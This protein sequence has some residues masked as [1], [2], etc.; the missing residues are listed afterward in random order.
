VSEGDEG[1]RGFVRIAVIGTG[2]M[3][4]GFAQALAPTHEVVVGSRGPARAAATASTAG[5]AGS[6]TYADAAANAE[7]VILTVPWEAMDETL[8]QL[9]DLAGTVVIDVSYPYNKREREA[10][11]GRSTAEAIQEQLPS[12]RV[13]KGWN[14]VHARHLTDPEVDGIAASVLIAGDDPQAKDVVFAIARDMGFHPVDAG[15]L[16]ATRD[17]DKLVGVML[18]VRLGP[19]RVLSP[20]PGHPPG[21]ARRRPVPGRR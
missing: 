9:G 3:G 1:R 15:P 12:A 2:K 13:F 5:A 17:L 20:P 14:H 18:F 4:R 19:F 8:G 21:S 7:V 6:G 16:R 11:R 10:L